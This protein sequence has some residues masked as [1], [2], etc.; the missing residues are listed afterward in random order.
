M[1]L[2]RARTSRVSAFTR[3]L[4]TKHDSSR[5]GI[6]ASATRVTSHSSHSMSA[7]MNTIVTTSTTMSSVEDDATPAR[8][9]RR[10]VIV[11]I[12]LPLRALS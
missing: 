1:S 11:D 4:E 5:N 6:A 12:R 9:R 8:S 10:A 3:L 2:W 7:S